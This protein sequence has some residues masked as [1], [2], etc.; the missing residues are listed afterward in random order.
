VLLC[1]PGEVYPEI[2]NGGVESL[3]GAD[4]PGTPVEVPPWRDLLPGRVKFV[5]GLANDEVGYII[6]RTQ[7]DRKPP[8]V[9]GAAKPEYGEVNSLGPETAP[10]LHAAVRELAAAPGIADR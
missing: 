6:P 8:Y 4:F 2:V 7:W 10:L 3:P 5:L 1:V 9:R